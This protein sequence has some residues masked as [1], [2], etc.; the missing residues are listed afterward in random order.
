[1]KGPLVNGQLQDRRTLGLSILLLL[2]LLAL[3]LVAGLGHWEA[4]GLVLLGIA[5]LVCGTGL[6]MALLRLNRAPYEQWE[7]ERSQCRAELNQAQDRL[8]Q[9]T[10]DLRRKT[11][12]LVTERDQAEFL[13]QSVSELA[14][15]LEPTQVLNGILHRAIRLVKACWGSILLLDDQ[16]RLR[17][18]ILSRMPPSMER[19][20]RTSRILDEGLAGW[21]IR[22]RQGTVIY[23]TTQDPRW[24]TFPGDEEVA[25][26]TV[27]VPFL[28]RDR[29][30]GIM[31]LTHTLPFQFDEN[32]LSM[33]QQLAQQAAICLENAAL[34]SIAEDERSKLAAILEG[35]ADAVLVV[36]LSSRV[37]LVNQATEQVFGVSEREILDRPLL[38]VIPHKEMVDLFASAS[39]EGKGVSRELVVTPGRVHY[40]SV[41][42]LPTVGWVAIL[43]DITYL[44]DL[45][46]MKSEF[47]STVSHDLRSPLT[48]IRGFVDLIPMIG[49]V[50]VEQQNAVERIRTAVVQMDELI[51]DLLDLGKIEAGIEMDMSLC[52]IE[53]IVAGTI[54]SLRPRAEEKQID[55][56]VAIEGPLP[57]V[58]GNAARLR[59]V[60]TNLVGNA[61]KYTPG[62]GQV[63][64]RMRKEDHELAVAV[65]DNGFGIAPADQER[66]FQ[67]FYR[68]QSPK[69]EA[70]SG[71]GLGLAIAR[72]I[73]EQHGGRI[74]AQSA[75]D[76]GSTFTFA[77]PVPDEGGL[78]DASNE[79]AA[80][81]L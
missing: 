61:I 52:Q 62:G 17:E 26:S 64:I 36:D 21:I 32:H 9:T 16:G 34:Y 72:S 11:D 67:K 31:V 76:Q 30:M 60:V 19:S 48:T 1:M 41:S 58:M 23:D 43:R 4:W 7:Q 27:A 56:R 5:T 81:H 3:N 6:A 70:I 78:S 37:L 29:V 63:L 42:P 47:V 40:G 24:L 28:R 25:R 35:T 44:K 10:Q 15:S 59:Q 54:E 51:G 80:Q 79:H 74:W 55:L 75:V 77:M 20:Q 46:R 12:Q 73:V 71:T 14:S 57:A 50:T 68:V 22:N 18:S 39:A 38:E 65:I 53:E 66:L 8:F 69:T 45:D 33:L 49:P 2:V 13:H